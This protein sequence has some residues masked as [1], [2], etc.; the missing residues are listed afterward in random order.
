MEHSID[1]E[2]NDGKRKKRKKSTSKK[3]TIKELKRL[4][5][6][7]AFIVTE[8]LKESLYLSHY[9]RKHLFK[10]FHIRK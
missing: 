3:I 6:S 5:I 2:T 1:S 4:I 8:I 10:L 7:A 9:C